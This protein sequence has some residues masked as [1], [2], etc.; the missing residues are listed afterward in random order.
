[1]QRHPKFTG[2]ELIA[3]DTQNRT[4]PSIGIMN[5]LQSY[6]I[7]PYYHPKTNANNAEPG[8]NLQKILQFPPGSSIFHHYYSSSTE[9]KNTFALT[10]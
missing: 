5:H 8:G 4:L 10:K 9:I 6:K 7:F 2:L 3:T 1:M